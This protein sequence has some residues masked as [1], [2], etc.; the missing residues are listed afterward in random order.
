[1][2]F[3]VIPAIDVS[4]GRLARFTREGPA[5]VSAFGGDPVV[6][7]R[8]FAGSGASWIHV[9]DMDLAFTG[10]PGDLDVVRS[11][12]ALGIRVQSGGGIAEASQVSAVLEAGAARAV[13]G[14]A[15]LGDLRR[16][17]DLI[18]SRGA[19]VAIGIEVDDGRIRARGRRPTDLP[20]AETVEA[21]IS[22]G[23]SML[24]VTAVARVG[25]LAGADLEMLVPMVALGCPVVAAGG[26]ATSVDLAA[27][28]QAGAVG[29]IVGRAALEGAIDLSEVIASLEAS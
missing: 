7:A 10:V 22:A 11:I 19:T 9:V 18:A 17:T 6:A 27:V 15:A 8:S 1:M 25:S 26:I 12:A 3:T 2:T 21:L 23:A 20:L 29:A 14:S 13:I 16:T 4:G 28:R 5:P 24:V